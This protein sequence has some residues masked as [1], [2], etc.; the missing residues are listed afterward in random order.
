MNTLKEKT[1]IMQIALIDH[2]PGEQTAINK[3][4]IFG[5]DW[6]PILLH[7]FV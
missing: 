3:V 2:W 5:F 4:K 7:I 1:V 6:C